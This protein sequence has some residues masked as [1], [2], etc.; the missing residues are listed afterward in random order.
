MENPQ[1]RK[2]SEFYY[3]GHSLEK[4][5]D[6]KNV[7][8]LFLVSPFFFKGKLIQYIGRVQRSEIAPLIYDYRDYKIDNTSIGL[9]Y[10]RNTY[11][12]ETWNRQAT[13]F[14]VSHRHFQDTEQ[15]SMTA[16]KKVTYRA[17]RFSF[18]QQ[19]GIYP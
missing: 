19:I 17:A 16:T 10:Q 15:V 8:C 4:V 6:L 3:Y 2:L 5:L 9:F 1:R 12:T 7:T 14:D 13:L 18:R 11:Y